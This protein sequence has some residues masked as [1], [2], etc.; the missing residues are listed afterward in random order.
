[1]HLCGENYPGNNIE[2]FLIHLFVNNGW[3]EVFCQKPKSSPKLYI[4]ITNVSNARSQ[5]FTVV[6]TTFHTFG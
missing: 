2:G 5:I 1:M 4:N 6:L 3:K